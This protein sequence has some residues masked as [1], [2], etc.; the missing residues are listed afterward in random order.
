MRYLLL[1]LVLFPIFLCAEDEYTGDYPLFGVENS[2]PPFY[3]FSLSG[4]YVD[5]QETSFRSPG[6]EGRK[7]RYTQADAALAFTLPCS[8]YFGFIFGAGWVGTEVDMDQNP[9][10]SE[11]NFNYANFSIG[12]FSKSFPDWTWTLTLAAFL[13]F[14]DFGFNDYTL[15]QG[16]LWGKYDFCKWLELDFGLI[17]EVGLNKEKVWPI[18]GLSFTPWDKVRINA[19][20]PINIAIEY[21]WS[22]CW[23]VAGSI[24]FLRNRHRV[25]SDEINPKGIFEYCT[26]GAELDLIF[27]PFKWAILKGFAGTTFDGDLKITD[28]HNNNAHHYKFNGSL[29]AGASAIASF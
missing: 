18:F 16:V 13:D 26:S 12:A 17:L 9:E 7:L 27:T 25:N 1:T 28:R 20:Y 11:T 8:E 22:K 21:D 23:T 14:E 19:I 2:P 4:Q 5:V 3:P 15:Y 6:L 10:F 29:Y 24:R